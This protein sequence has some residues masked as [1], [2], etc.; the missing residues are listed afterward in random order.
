MTFRM[1]API[2]AALLLAGAP[3]C[4]AIPDR[5]APAVA[6]LDIPATQ[7][8][9]RLP[10]DLELDDRMGTAQVAQLAAA[11]DAAG[12]VPVDGYRA[13]DVAYSAAEQ[14]LIVFLVDGTAEPSDGLVDVG[15]VT[16]G[17]DSLASCAR[18]CTLRLSSPRD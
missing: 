1:L 17:M 3:A 9:E 18:A 8:E 7:L 16:S 6:V 4:S 2:V 10:V 13:G 14:S 5:P 15:R 12:A 11:L